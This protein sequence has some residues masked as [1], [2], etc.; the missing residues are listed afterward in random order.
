MNL[1]LQL[2]D[3]VEQSF[4]CRGATGDVNI[5][6]DDAVAA[7]NDGIGI[8]VIASPVGAGAHR[9]DPARFGHLI[10]YLTQRGSH[11]IAKRPG[12]NHH[13]RLARTWTEHDPEPVEVIARCAGLHHFNRATCETKGHWP[14][15][16][17]SPPVD[18]VVEAG[19]DKAFLYAAVSAHSFNPIR[20][21][22]CSIHR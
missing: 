9:N 21:H 2:N 12:H 20:G 1:V 15:R 6:R 18:N 14:H 19:G 11:F 7:S 3:A 22:P 10:V 13:V 16:A 17:S 8:M 5:Y 4:R